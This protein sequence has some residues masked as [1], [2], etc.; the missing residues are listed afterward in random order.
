MYLYQKRKLINF[1]EAWSCEFLC[2]DLGIN[3]IALFALVPATV[4]RKSFLVIIRL[5]RPHLHQEP[6]TRATQRRDISLLISA[7]R[8]KIHGLKLTVVN[9]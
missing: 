6:Y 2:R 4:D 1:P 5:G 8:L 9:P 3:S 7:L